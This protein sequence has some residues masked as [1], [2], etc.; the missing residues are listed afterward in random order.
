MICMIIFNFS[1]NRDK[2]II[3]PICDFCFSI[4]IH[5]AF[6]MS[7]SISKLSNIL[8][9]SLIAQCPKSMKFCIYKLSLIKNIITY[10]FTAYLLRYTF[11]ARLQTTI[12]MRLIMVIN[13]SLVILMTFLTLQ[14]F[15]LCLR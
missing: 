5:A 2:N 13:C 9:S 7:F 14:N 6:S 3:L 11:A 15:C 4:K 10:I 1:H 12:T 8:N